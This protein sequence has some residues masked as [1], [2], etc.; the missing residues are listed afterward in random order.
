MTREERERRR[1]AVSPW[2]ALAVWTTLVL[3]AAVVVRGQSA[4]APLTVQATVVRSCSVS[5]PAAVQADPASPPRTVTIACG[6]ART[7]TALPA[8][9]AI[10]RVAGA[11][12]GASISSMQSPRSLTVSV[13]F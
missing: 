6:G 9:P 7:N 4:Q 3:A 13:D 12:A 2:L 1:A 8:T 11:P 5:T 10:L